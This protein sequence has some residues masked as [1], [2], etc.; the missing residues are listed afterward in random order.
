VLAIPGHGPAVGLAPSCTS[1]P[2]KVT[3][4]PTSNG[5]CLVASGG[6]PGSVTGLFVRMKAAKPVAGAM[7]AG[8]WLCGQSGS[9]VTAGLVRGM[10]MGKPDTLLTVGLSWSTIKRLSG[11]VGRP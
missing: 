11:V 10:H 9:A 6:T 2:A 8:R 3:Q 1:V 4:S 5:A 7:A